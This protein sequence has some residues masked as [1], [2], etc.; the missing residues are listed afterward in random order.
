[1]KIVFHGRN[2]Q[3][4]LPGFAE[5]VGPGHDIVA[6]SDATGS[7]AEVDAFETADVLIGIALG[8]THP[9]PAALKL[10]HAP[11][12]G[13]DAIDRSLL[14][15]GTPLCCCFGHEHA[16]AEYVLAA[17]LLRHVPIPSADRDLR[18]GRWTYWAGGG[19]QTR[20]ELGGR[21]IGLLGYGHIGRE[22]AKRAKAFGMRVTVANRSPVAADGVVDQAFGLDR[23]AAFMGSADYIVT[24]LPALPETLG[25]V[26]AGALAAMR[27][28]G[29]IVNVGR[30]PV[31]DEAALF[32]A[33]TERRIGGAI[34]D[35]WYVYP[36]PGTPAARPGHLPFHDLDNC[37]LTP[38][39]SGWTD[40]TIRRRQETMAEN[41]RRLA[42]GAP[43]IN[44]L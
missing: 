21:T 28:D 40:G 10:Y 8:A 31:I 24:S 39:M 41:I 26:D 6:V 34:I 13:V 37:I 35:T 16:I 15:A 30:G 3:A 33:L 18:E 9:R 38:H 2:A 12:A 36:T 22:V 1:M 20:S 14:P 25:L 5:M 29:V 44:R 27:P 42:T 32:A 17:L 23:L 7:A 4:F 11:A 19:G 43:L